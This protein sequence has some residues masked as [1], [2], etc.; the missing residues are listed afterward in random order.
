MY[1]GKL[2]VLCLAAASLLLVNGVA[3]AGIIDPCNSTC[4]I[5]GTGGGTAPWGLFICPAG[6]TN[7]W[8]DQQ[9]LPGSGD[10]FIASL[11]IVELVTGDPIPNIPGS[12]FWVVD[13][14]PVND[15][16]LC[17]GSASTGADSTTN[18]AGATT[19]GGF[20]GTA[21]GGCANGASV[22][23]QGSVLLDPATGCTTDLCKQILF[24]S[25][26][27]TGDLAISLADLTTFSFSF[28]P[29]AYDQCC[30]MN[31]DGNITLADLSLFAFHFGPPGHECN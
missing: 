2:A 5:S 17:G 18:A 3:S 8:D 6:D 19:I 9:G 15:I 4:V 16:A 27:I 21:G 30:D 12:D 28:P 24:R 22:I 1:K 25:P 31:V 20:G 14:D 23:V 7:N 29:N 26:D 10:G 13:C 11:V